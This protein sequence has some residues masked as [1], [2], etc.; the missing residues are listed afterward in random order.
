MNFFQFFKG[1]TSLQHEQKGDQCVAN[2]IWGK[3]KLEYDV[4]LEK[5]G[6]ESHRSPERVERLKKKINICKDE[7]ARQ[8]CQSADDLIEAGY[9]EEAREYYLLGLELTKSKRFRS[10]LKNRLDHLERIVDREMAASVLQSIPEPTEMFMRQDV[11]LDDDTYFEALCHTLPPE[12]RRRYKRYGEPFKSGYIAL[13]RGDFISAAEALKQAQ[14][15]H[16]SSDSF[17]AL[18]LA[19]AYVNLGKNES[20]RSLLEPFV[21][22]HPDALPAYRML[23]EILWDNGEYDRAGVL[24]KTVPEH[25]FETQ[26]F[27]LLHGENLYRQKKYT[28]AVEWYQMALS[29][30]GWNENITRALA[31]TLESAKQP[32]AARDLYAQIISRCNKCHSSAAFASQVDPFTRRRYAELS[33]AAGDHSTEILELFLSLVRDDPEHASLYYRNVS[34]IYAERGDKMEALRFQKFA[35]QFESQAPNDENIH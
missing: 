33:L 35:E 5:L 8:H 15:T 34:L 32:T 25:L 26:A 3:A 24:L 22:Q 17:I 2:E 19:T 16:V 12:I 23:C 14:E 9:T 6:G 13:N 10:I 28:E 11:P 31:V 21:Q 27:I 30:Y 4:A 29:K 20:A 7:L 1:K 18:E